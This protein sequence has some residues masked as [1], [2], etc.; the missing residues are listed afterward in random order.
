MLYKDI[1]FRFDCPIELVSDR[2]GHFL[3]KVMD[4]LLRFF[5]V[6][7]KKLTP[8]YPQ[9]N[10]QAE[11][12]NKQ[13]VRILT[14][15]FNAHRIDWDVKLSAALWAYRTAFKVGTGLTPFKLA[16]GF[17]AITPVEHVVPSLRMLIVDRLLSEE[18]LPFW[19]EVLQELDE[20]RLQSF[21]L[22][23]LVQQRRKIFVD[24]GSK[25]RIF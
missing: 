5:L 22:A 1:F 18:S 10:G 8:Y 11:S 3:N 14:K 16:F 19:M 13:L 12:T 21:A 23:Q 17:E 2:G 24:R 25:S 9:A 7:H 6:A 4:K 15:M 20:V